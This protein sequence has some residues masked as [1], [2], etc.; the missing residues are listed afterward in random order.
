MII[1]REGKTMIK[2]PYCGSTA[3]PKQIGK[4]TVS[5]NGRYFC[6]VYECGCGCNFEALFPR[7]EVEEYFIHYLDDIEG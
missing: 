4:A 2:C 1:E 7:V 3:Q 6:E 5:D